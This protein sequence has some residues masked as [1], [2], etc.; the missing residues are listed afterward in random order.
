MV[1][2]LEATSSDKRGGYKVGEI[3][4]LSN[5]SGFTVFA[6]LLTDGYLQDR[7]VAED[8]RKRYAL[9]YD[10]IVGRSQNSLTGVIT[11]PSNYQGL[12]DKSHVEYLLNLSPKPRFMDGLRNT[13]FATAVGGPL[14]SRYKSVFL[15]QPMI[16]INSPR[17][18]L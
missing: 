8:L 2:F 10:L 4:E 6:L 11:A 14:Q 16:L 9:E 7:I 12:V 17:W 18:S 3:L 15:K 13:L 5:S 1:E